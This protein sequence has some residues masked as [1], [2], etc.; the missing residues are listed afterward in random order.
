MDDEQ[1][2]TENILVHHPSWTSAERFLLEVLEPSTVKGYYQPLTMISL[3]GDYALGGRPYNLKPFHR[4]SL[5][6]HMANTSLVIVLIYILFGQAWI[7]A[8][9]GLLFGLHPMTVETIAWVSQRKTV[10]SAFFA[11]W[12]LI[13]YVYF[14]RKKAWQ[15][16]AGC[17]LTYVLALMSKPTAIPLPV[18]MLLLDYWPLKRL[19]GKSFVEKLPLFTIGGVFALI[20]YVSQSRTWGVTLP[21]QYGFHYIPLLFFHNTAF[22]LSKIGWPVPASLSPHYASTTPIALSD[23]V[24]LAGIFIVCVLV[25]L[26]I[27]LLRWT[28]GIVTGWLFFFVSIVP[29]IGIIRF[30]TMIAG[31]RYV[32]LPSIGLL[33]LIALLLNWLWGPSSLKPATRR[34]VIMMLVLL[35]AGTEAVA[36]RKYLVYWRDGANLYKHMLTVTPGVVML[37]NNLGITLDSQGKLDEAA[38]QFNQVLKIAPNY[39]RAHIN[40]G[41]ILLRQKKLVEA[42]DHYN[43]AL[44]SD[45]KYDEAHYHLAVALTISGKLDEAL[46]HFR[47]AV[48]LTSKPTW[49]FL[50]GLAW[51]L[52]THPNPEVRNPT[53]AVDLAKR[54]EMLTLNEYQKAK[55][56]GTL[57][58]AYAANNQL[59]LAV[60]K[61][62]RALS[63]ASDFNDVTMSNQ[64]LGQLELYKQGKA[65]LLEPNEL[66]NQLVP[67]LPQDGDN[68]KPFQF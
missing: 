49:Y 13:L 50:N 34:I 19:K 23:P 56:L 43:Q 24:I 25:N 20:I 32:Y 47:E 61:S 51:V 14:A 52:A 58:A 10:L 6:F 12:S 31:D 30:G 27:F 46:K 28:K 37:H 62:Q 26:L 2:L 68:E 5:L 39:E 48:R 22:Y 8:G 45:P 63:L 3:M 42:I 59:D 33:L 53:E 17:L 60:E 64:I 67:S 29:S 11:L 16:Y 40:L 65:Y 38:D 18:L 44:R 35:L 36:T 41:N 21:G 4:T 66:K 1:Y 9:V 7:A 57:A 15:L 54:A 55:V